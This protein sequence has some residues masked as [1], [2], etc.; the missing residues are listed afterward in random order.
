M[1]KLQDDYNRSRIYGHGGSHND[2]HNPNTVADFNNNGTLGHDA[3]QGDYTGS[4]GNISSSGRRKKGKSP[5]ASNGRSGANAATKSD[6][7]TL[8]AWIGGISAGVGVFY[9]DLIGSVNSD[10]AWLIPVG[11][12]CV[13]AFLGHKLHKTVSLMFVVGAIGGVIYLFA[14]SGV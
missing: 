13:G 6:P 14:N 9:T 12:I 10:F 7:Q 4:Y 11:A 1:S 8:W 2:A 5:A 3:P